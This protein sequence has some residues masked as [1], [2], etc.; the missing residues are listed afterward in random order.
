MALNDPLQPGDYILTGSQE[1]EDA[2][3]AIW[4]PSVGAGPHADLTLA[5]LNQRLDG[6]GAARPHVFPTPQD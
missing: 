6:T 4:K 2:L 5:E 1:A 3:A